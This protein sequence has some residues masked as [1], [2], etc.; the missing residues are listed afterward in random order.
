MH[1]KVVKQN[2]RL[3]LDTN[4]QVE[5]IKELAHANAEL[6][7]QNVYLKARLVLPDNFD[8]KFRELRLRQHQ[9]DKLNAQLGELNKRQ[10]WIEGLEEA[11]GRNMKM[12]ANPQAALRELIARAD[13]A[14]WEI[15][16]RCAL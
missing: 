2:D 3:K 13:D 14:E 16:R 10:A 12:Q 15:S 5:R 6:Q 7:E 1:H 9:I 11:F 4:R 8:D